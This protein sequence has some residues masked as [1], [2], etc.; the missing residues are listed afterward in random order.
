MLWYSFGKNETKCRNCENDLIM[1]VIFDQ[2]SFIHNALNDSKS[3]KVKATV[4]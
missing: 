2:S 3:R 1:L 4:R